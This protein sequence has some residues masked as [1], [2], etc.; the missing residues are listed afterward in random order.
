LEYKRFPTFCW[1]KSAINALGK[2]CEKPSVLEDCDKACRSGEKGSKKVGW[3]T[4]NPPEKVTNGLF[5]L[6][7]ALRHQLAGCIAEVFHHRGFGAR[8]TRSEWVIK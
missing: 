6:R 7:L 5:G 8:A 2:I 3:R 1:S 4:A